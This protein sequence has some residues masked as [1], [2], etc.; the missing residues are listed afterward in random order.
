PNPKVPWDDWVDDYGRVREAI[1]ATYP[2]DFHDFNTRI[3]APGGFPRN[4]PARERQWNTKTGKANFAV[5]ASLNASFDDGRDEKVLRLMTLRSNDQFNTT[6]YGDHDRFRG[7]Y[8][9][10][11]VLLMNRYD[12]E[13]LGIRDEA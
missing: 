6:V 7:I 11:M 8:G 13:R 12:M 9:S 5:P 10:R 4:L 1:E 2:E 3:G